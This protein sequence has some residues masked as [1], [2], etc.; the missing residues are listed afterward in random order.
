VLGLAAT[1]FSPFLHEAIVRLGLLVPFEQVPPLL[2][3]FTGVSVGV[4]TVR[5]L[6]EQAGHALVTMEEAE[7]AQLQQELPPPPDGP[8]V[9]QLSADGAMVPLLHGE[10]AEVRTLVIG[11][12]TPDEQHDP[13]ATN[14][15]YFSRLADAATFIDRATLAT[16]RAG[17][18]R[19]EVVCAVMDG[20]DWLQRLVDLHRSD[21]VRI[22][23]FPHA[24]EH[25]SHVA[26]AVFGPGTE[27]ATTWLETHCTTLKTGNPDEV[28]AAIRSL[29]AVGDAVAVRDR[30]LAY[31]EGRRDQIRYAHF[32]QRGF[33][34]GSGAVE[35]A[36]KLVVEARLKGSGMHW[37]R[38]NVSPMV[39][40]RATYC[41]GAWDERWQAMRAHMQ[42]A[43]T[44]HRYKSL[45]P[46]PPAVA[47][48]PLDRVEPPP[49]SPRPAE[50]PKVIAGRPTE[51]HP[52]EHPYNPV[53][54]AR[55]RECS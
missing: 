22:L 12:L 5:R 20:A 33:P 25:L 41:S 36:N 40:L 13:H 4:E 53:L 1:A 24:A 7:Y 39:A 52:W 28:L 34:I 29:P 44:K 38:G 50:P 23:D 32:R 8:V 47:D 43:R 2:R 9:Q 14:L 35:S 6:T 42:T 11:E 48:P 17:T 16:H 45:I 15:S 55:A 49:T 51:H 37:A 26:Q 46:T 54:A 27:A 18:E 31:L 10:W 3:F 19:A 21:A 30:V